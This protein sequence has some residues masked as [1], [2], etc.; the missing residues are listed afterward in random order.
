MRA[1]WSV[2]VAVAVLG[3]AGATEA[4][5]GPRVLKSADGL[6][7]VSI[8][9]GATSAPGRIRITVLPPSRYPPEL[10]KARTARGTKVY[11]LA[12]D[13]LRFAKPVTVTRRIAGLPKTLPALASRDARGRWE[14]LRRQ[15]VQVAGRTAV[16]S[17]ETRHFSSFVTVESGV[18]LELSPDA[19]QGTVDHVFD[20]TATF[21]E[22]PTQSYWWDG[23]PWGPGAASSRV[24]A[25][26][27]GT[28][29]VA[30]NGRTQGVSYVCNTTGRGVFGIRFLVKLSGLEAL[31]GDA[32]LESSLSGV[33]TCTKPAEVKLVAACVAIVH[34]ALGAFPS[35]LEYRLGFA[36]AGLPAKPT[37]QL[38][39]PDTNHGAAAE[40]PIDTSGR[41]TV[42][43]GIDAFGPKAVGRAT[44]G[45][46]DITS[47]LTGL[48]GSTVDVT[49]QERVAAGTCP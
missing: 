41:A 44:V 34:R 48:L 11:A 15:R 42:Q 38:T 22:P 47:Q 7:T 26:Q 4:A 16:L 49:A 36:R 2:A 25:V 8:P 24:I 17:G 27:R 39:S 46:A 45:G 19:V 10:R 31:F 29:R 14:L 1:R 33:A 40:A 37:V 32:E 43:T 12:P 21:S 20:A 18:R 35:F 13:G 9:A 30:G 28:S 6:L 23:T 5:S 3:Q